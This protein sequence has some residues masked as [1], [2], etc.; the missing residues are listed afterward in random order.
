MDHY[1][2]LKILVDTAGIPEMLK[3]NAFEIATRQADGR[4]MP[5]I[6]ATFPND[7][8]KAQQVAEKGI[9]IDIGQAGEPH[10]LEGRPYG[11]EEGVHVV[12]RGVEAMHA[13]M[14]D[15]TIGEEPSQIGRHHDVA[16]VRVAPIVKISWNVGT[17]PSQHVVSLL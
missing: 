4:L 15:L 5:F 6:N 7:T 16:Y 3:H 9:D 10:I 14:S 2:E 1:S 12:V 13:A 11:T 8:S 17:F